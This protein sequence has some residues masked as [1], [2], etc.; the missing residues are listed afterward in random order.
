MPDLL[1]LDATAQL[2]A[3]N[4]GRVS[5]VDLLETV[6]RR[7]QAVNGEVNAVVVT[8]WERAS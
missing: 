6:R 7:W 5:A 4:S 2:A 8:D 3:L 1:A